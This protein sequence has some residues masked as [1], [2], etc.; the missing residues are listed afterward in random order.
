MM[1]SRSRSAWR[2]VGAERSRSAQS[3]SDRDVRHDVLGQMGDGAVRLA[4]THRRTVRPPRRIHQNRVLLVEREPLVNTRRSVADHAA[5]SRTAE[6]GILEKAAQLRNPC[7]PCGKRAVAGDAGVARLRTELWGKRKRYV[8]AI[9]WQK[10]GG[11]IRPF[12][13]HDSARRQII[14]AEFAEFGRARKPV[15]IRVHQDEARQLV[16]LH[17]REGR[18]W[19]FDGLIA[20]EVADQR[21]RER[22]LAGAQIA[23]QRHQIAGLERERDLGRK[24]RRRPFARQHHRET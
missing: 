18:T 10:S 16:G 7:R 23:G 8:E 4:V 22:G 12:H 5:P 19:H 6:T 20:G 1:N 13:E 2:I 21:A 14:E 15:E 17:Q 24:P 11:A 3:G 9:G